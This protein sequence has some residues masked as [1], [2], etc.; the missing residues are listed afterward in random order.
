LL[1]ELRAGKLITIINGNRQE[2]QLGEFW[3]VGPSDD[4]MLETEDD[5]VV[6]QTIHLP[7]S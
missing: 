1:Y 2:R 3:I 7:E 6:V 4:V 5:S